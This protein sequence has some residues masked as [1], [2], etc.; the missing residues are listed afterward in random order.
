M[1]GSSNI[2]TRYKHRAKHFKTQKSE[3]AIAQFKK[4]REINLIKEEEEAEVINKYFNGNFLLQH[5]K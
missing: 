4:K 2:F 3:E 5:T 1:G